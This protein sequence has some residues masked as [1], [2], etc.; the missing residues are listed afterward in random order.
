[1]LVVIG[2]IEDSNGKLEACRLI[3]TETMNV[4]DISIKRIKDAV[5]SNTKIKGFAISR[6]NDLYAGRV[7]ETVVRDK[8][9]KFSWH[10]IPNLTGNG[11][12]INPEDNKYITLIGWKG[13]AEAKQYYLVNYKGEL[14]KLNLKEFIA[15]IKAD[16]INGALLSKNSELPSISRDLDIEII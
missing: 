2:K 7:R 8:G 6:N 13:F 1:M 10:R 15:K 14:T 12:L 11:E 9:L 5:R 16:E 3:D 4:G